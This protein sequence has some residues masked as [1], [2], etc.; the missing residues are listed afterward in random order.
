MGR[1]GPK[2]SPLRL[3]GPALVQRF[4]LDPDGGAGDG[5]AGPQVPA[6]D[7][8]AELG[9]V[10]PPAAGGPDGEALLE[11]AFKD[12]WEKAVL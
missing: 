9:R 12:L 8:L 10:H 11:E 3:G 2:A 4:L 5:L 7:V 6:Q 1:F